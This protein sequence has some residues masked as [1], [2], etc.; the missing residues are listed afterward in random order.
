MVL[1]GR[2]NAVVHPGEASFPPFG[3]YC[4]VPLYTKPGPVKYLKFR[5]GQEMDRFGLKR[6]DRIQI[7]RCKHNVDGKEL[8]FDIRYVEFDPST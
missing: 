7:K 5:T 2:V 3:E 4:T 1:R 6:D 8:V